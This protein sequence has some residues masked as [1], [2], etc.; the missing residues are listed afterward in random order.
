MTASSQPDRVLLIS[1]LHL[2]PARPDLVQALYA[3]LRKQAAA[4]RALYILGVLFDAWVGDDDD[5]PLYADIAAAL[6]RFVASGPALYL[7]HGNRDF[8]LGTCYA[9]ACGA[10]LLPEPHVLE[11]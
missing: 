5:T 7:M 3:F 2:S 11:H 6:Q 9:K 1:D 10:T 4:C 8:L